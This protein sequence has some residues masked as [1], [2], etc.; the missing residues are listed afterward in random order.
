MWALSLLL[1]FFSLLPPAAAALEAGGVAHSWTAS[2]ASFVAARAS[3]GASLWHFACLRSHLWL[4]GE[5][6]KRTGAAARARAPLLLFSLESNWTEQGS[7]ALHRHAFGH[8]SKGWSRIPSRPS[9]AS[10]G[11]PSDFGPKANTTS[12][13]GYQ[14]KRTGNRP[15][16]RWCLNSRISLN[17]GGRWT[18]TKASRRNSVPSYLKPPL[19][20]APAPTW[21]EP[22]L[23]RPQ[24]TNN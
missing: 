15:P 22:R 10:W 8:G 21:P 16:S 14:P 23:L 12:Y 7:G 13:T 3:G 19:R 5:R 18:L 6:V 24:G 4:A 2:R 17:F 11:P 1:L 9:Q 20:W